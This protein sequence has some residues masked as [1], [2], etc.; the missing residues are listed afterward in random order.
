MR[1]YKT[2]EKRNKMKKPLKFYI[3]VIGAKI[4]I[5]LMRL[6]KRNATNLPGELM[7]IFYPD[8]LK[9][10]DMPRNVIAVTGT[11][12]KTTVSNMIG[13]ILTKNG[14]DIINNSFG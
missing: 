8:L 10:F 9:Y 5:K 7:L 2:E 3:S 11:N 13:N 6:M 12:G 14:Y 1:V 4:L